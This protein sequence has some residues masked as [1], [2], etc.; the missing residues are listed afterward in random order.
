MQTW[1]RKLSE[2]LGSRVLESL[3]SGTTL[4]SGQNLFDVPHHLI[5]VTELIKVVQQFPFSVRTNQIGK[6]GVIH[7]VG[8]RILSGILDNLVI[9][10]VGVRGFGELGFSSGESNE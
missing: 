5:R 1:G 7:R 10:S 8:I 6:G 4:G 3:A 9:R 2:F